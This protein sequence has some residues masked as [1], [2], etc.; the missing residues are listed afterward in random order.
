MPIQG[1]VQTANYLARL[2]VMV[3]VDGGYLESNLKEQWG[4]DTSVNYARFRESL[5]KYLTFEKEG[6][7]I[8]RIYYYDAIYEEQE[9]YQKL[10]GI[11]DPK[12][13][14]RIKADIEAQKLKHRQIE[15]TDFFTLRT[16]RLALK[17]KGD[18][19]QK[20]VDGLLAADIVSK[21]YQDQYDIAL[22]LAGDDDFVDVVKSVKDAGKQVYGFY[23]TRS[24]SS[25]LLNSLDVRWAI[26]KNFATEIRIPQRAIRADAGLPPI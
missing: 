14:Q 6:Y 11:T 23:F 3:F 15:S 4:K 22:L 17:G 8:I 5:Q 25:R 18:F 19:E 24:T 1:F 2:K 12:R 16:G 21:G 10:S 20:G 9:Q 13:L 7:F 26:D